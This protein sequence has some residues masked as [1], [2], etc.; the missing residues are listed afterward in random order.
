[1][2][3]RIAFSAALAALILSA[4]P[5][6]CAT[7]DVPYTE[8]LE[9]AD[10]GEIE[11]IKW[12]EDK[13]EIKFY[14]YEGGSYTT[15][16][17]KY[18]DFKKEMLEKGIEVSEDG[19][20]GKY[21][22]AVVTAIQ[23]AVSFTMMLMI[24]KMAGVGQTWKKNKKPPKSS[25]KFSDVAGLD[26]VKEDL[27]TVVDFLKAPQKYKEA[28]AEIPSGI[29]LYGPPGTGKT[30]LAR[31]VAGE[32][33]VNFIATSGSDFDEKYVG[34]GASRMRKMFSDAK[35]NAPCI[36]FVDE[37]D[38]LGGKRNASQSNTDRQTLNSFLAEMDGFDGSCGVVV[39]AATNRLEDLDPALTR[40]GRF[41]SHFAVGLPETSS[42]RKK[43]IRL[44]AENKRFSNDVD[45]DVLS[46]EMVGS[47]P[48][49]VKAVLND[50]A[51]MA[52]SRNSGVINREILDEAW[53][54]QLL[55]GHLKRGGSK[56]N[57][58]ISAWHEAGHA[59]VGVLFGQEL[60][61][62]SVIPSTSGTGG[63]TF[64]VPKQ[65]GP[66]SKRELENQIKVF[67]A[68]RCA[69]LLLTGDKD[70]VTT[71]AVND[72]EKATGLI[73]QIICEFGMDQG[74]L[75]YD[76]L[77][78]DT[79]EILQDAHRISAEL[80]ARTQELLEKNYD[81]LKELAEELEQKETLTE[82]EVSAILKKH[83]AEAETGKQEKEG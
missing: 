4:T 46:K 68:G 51:I 60:T 2:R 19:F 70:L 22:D 62:V 65:N 53:I 83:G 21:E 71:G 17:P 78:V 1:M 44:Y 49:M 12:S 69:E 16:N 52:V 7:K 11:K 28:G 14:D 29:L 82:K 18:D 15:D 63:A 27:I 73:R 56:E 61:K 79:E 48:A 64:L 81:A 77:G 43:V 34:V 24:L 74:L 47:S 66:F 58:K 40:P 5:A 57:L 23:L 30:L 26:E 75:N 76:V 9:M 25:V 59:L 54:K 8:F 80:E 55:E 33:G 13:D 67:Y 20:L 35:K 6:Q 37:I 31:A 39:M 72:I 3:K 10:G 45:F 32:A 50:A 36:I 38:S 42:E 41:D